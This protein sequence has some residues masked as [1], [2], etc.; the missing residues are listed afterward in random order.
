MSPEEIQR[1]L[2]IKTYIPFL[3]QQNQKAMIQQVFDGWNVLLG[4]NIEHSKLLGKFNTKIEAIKFVKRMGFGGYAIRQ[5]RSFVPIVEGRVLP[6]YRPRR[7]TWYKICFPK[8]D[9]KD[10]HRVYMKK[11]IAI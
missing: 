4:K 6:S 9:S 3:I 10:W 5:T 1:L 2:S 11:K 7:G 8:N